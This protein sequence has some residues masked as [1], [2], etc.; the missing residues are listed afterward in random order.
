MGRMSPALTIL[1]LAVVLI[2]S[3][4]GY[5]H[6]PLARERAQELVTAA[7]DAGVGANVT[8]PTA[9]ALYGTAAPSVCKLFRGSGTGLNLLLNPGGGH[10]KVITSRAREYGRVVVQVYCPQRLAE[11]DRVT[12]GLRINRSTR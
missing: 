2:V 9:E 3:G 7:K 1:V 11:Y 12:R 10:Y 6:S 4:C 8:V 5:N